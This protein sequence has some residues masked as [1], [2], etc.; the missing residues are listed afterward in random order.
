MI[1]LFFGEIIVRVLAYIFLEVLFE[2]VVELVCRLL[3]RERKS[4]RGDK[5]ELDWDALEE[6][7][8]EEEEGDA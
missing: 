4:K 6:S 7:D 1:P 2:G 5:L 3:G 8:E